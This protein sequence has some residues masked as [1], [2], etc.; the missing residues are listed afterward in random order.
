MTES[1]ALARQ[2]QLAAAAALDGDAKPL[3]AFQRSQFGDARTYPWRTEFGHDEL[4]D[5]LGQ[6]FDEHEPVFSETLFDPRDHFCIIDRIADL[7]GALGPRRQ[8]DFE[9]ELDRLRHAAL[10]LVDADE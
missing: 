10:P 4:R 2:L 7:V 1:Q 6:C 3:H 9:I 8:P 5:V